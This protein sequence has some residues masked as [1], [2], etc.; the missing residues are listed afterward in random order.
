M[1]YSIA[2]D[3][4]NSEPLYY[5]VAIKSF[6]SAFEA[7]YGYAFAAMMISILPTIIVYVFLTN[8]IIGGM[9]AGAVKE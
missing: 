5:T 8:K 6:L 1:N 2:Y 3:H 7:N 4:N 9:T